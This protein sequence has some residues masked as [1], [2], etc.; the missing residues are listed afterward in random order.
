MKTL[1]I[2]DDK[3]YEIWNLC[4]EVYLQYGR[5]LSFPDKTD[6]RKTY[7]WRYARALAIKFNEWE[8]DQETAKSFVQIAVSYAKAGNR[9]NKGLA[10]LHQGNLLQICYDRLQKEHNNT[11]QTASSLKT[12]KSWVDD[13][14]KEG[15]AVTIFLKRKTPDSFCNLV[16]WVQA[17]KIS[18]LYL[19][20]SR[21]CSKALAKL[22]KQDPFQ[23][24]L[25]PP[26]TTLY[27]LRSQFLDNSENREMSKAILKNDWRDLCL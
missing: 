12:I 24:G 5:K 3:I 23:R 22:S 13:K 17:S 10:A 8:F 20:L 21:S 6:P 1:D 26:A 18:P 7:Q 27:K 14:V 15:D 9:L 2:S 4:V 11:E 16:I 25:L 19:S